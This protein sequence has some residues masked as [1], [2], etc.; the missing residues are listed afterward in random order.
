MGITP[1]EE[2]PV[3]LEGLPEE[4]G[5]STADAADRIGLDPDEQPNY[6]EDELRGDDSS[7]DS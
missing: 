3:D 7:E 5:V 6:T 2:R 1:D 4:E